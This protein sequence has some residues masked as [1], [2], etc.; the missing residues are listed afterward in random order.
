[1]LADPNGSHRRIGDIASEVGFS[2]RS[3]FNREFRQRY[4]ITPS[5]MRAMALWE[6]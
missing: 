2:D 4:G 3:H 6:R 5:D 1:M